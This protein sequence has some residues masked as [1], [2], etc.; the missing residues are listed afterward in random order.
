MSSRTRQ[1]TPIEIRIVGSLLEKEQTTPEVY[2]LTMS[3][4]LAACNQ[5][6]NR[7]P[8]LQLTETEVDAGLETLRQDVLVWRTEG[9]RSERWQQSVSRRWALDSAAKKAVMTLLL[10]RGPQTVGELHTRS[11][12]L[13]AFASLAEVEDTLRRMA[14]VEEPLVVELPRRVGQ[15]ENRWVH[16]VGEVAEPASALDIAPPPEPRRTVLP[17]PATAA[18]ADAVDAMA[19]RIAQLEETVAS[20]A[21]ELA[22][23]KSELGL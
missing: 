21:K 17:G 8:V 3:A 4:L 6:T 23:L 10:L 20:L 11:E 14:E 5:K 22:A 16:T 2:P 13:H 7:D 9:A 1:L 19:A 12:R 18:S 15:K